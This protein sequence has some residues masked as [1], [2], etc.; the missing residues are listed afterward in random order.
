MDSYILPI[1]SKSPSLGNE[2]RACKGLDLLMG[3]EE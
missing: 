1:V 2:C 3:F